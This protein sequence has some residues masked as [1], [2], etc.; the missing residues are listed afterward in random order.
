MSSFP[1]IGRVDDEAFLFEE[2]SEPD[3]TEVDVEEAEVNLLEADVVAGE[4]L[5]DGDAMGVPTDTSVP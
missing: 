4:E 2:V 5:A 3:R 1:G